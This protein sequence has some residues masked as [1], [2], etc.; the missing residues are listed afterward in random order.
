MKQKIKLP[1]GIVDWI[2][3]GNGADAAIRKE[4][5]NESLIITHPG[6][7]LVYG[8][9]IETTART[10]HGLS[11]NEILLFGT[12]GAACKE[13]VSGIVRAYASKQAAPLKAVKEIMRELPVRLFL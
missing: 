2:G 8:D 12:N 9:G 10:F 3:K 13:I 4:L 11:D 5:G 7:R 6:D 1:K